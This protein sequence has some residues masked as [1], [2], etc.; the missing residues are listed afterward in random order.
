MPRRASSRARSGAG[1]VLRLL[2]QE[3][4]DERVDARD[5]ERRDGGDLRRVAPGGDEGG[6]AVLVGVGDVAVVLA[7]EHER[8]VDRDARAD[9]LADGDA[10]GRRRGDLDEDVRPPEEAVEP[11]GLGDRPFDVEG[12]AREDLEGDPA[13]L[14]VGGVLGG[15]EVG[16]R[17]DVA[18]RQV[19]VDV[20]GVLP[21]VGEVRDRGSRSRRRSLP[22]AWAKIVGFDVTP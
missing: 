4:V 11:P 14:G 19:V 10:A 7:V 15:E 2:G 20:E 9:E 17:G 13:V 3:L 16:P 18:A 1:A 12:E 22:I 21:F 6:D 5:E 8:H